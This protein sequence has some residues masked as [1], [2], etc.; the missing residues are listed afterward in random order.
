MSNIISCRTGVFGDIGEAFQR[1][2]RAGVR[3]AETPPAPEGDYAG[4]AA[5]A[6]A[7]GVAIATISTQLNVG[8]DEQAAALEPVI[9]GAASIGVAK[10]FISIK[11]GEDTPPADSYAR[12]RRISEYAAARGVSLCMETH[13][14]FGTNGDVARQTIEAVN[15]PAFRYN[16]DTA[17]IYYYNEGT[18]SVTELKK[19]A[20][21]VGSVHLKDTDG[22]Y[23]SGYFPELGQGVVD[24]PEVFR[25]L[26]A[27]GFL[28]PYT[29]ELEGNCLGPLAPEERQAFLERCVAYLRSIG[30]MD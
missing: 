12:M 26:G 5:K 23:H 28:G 22:G 17:N 16:F 7:A 4:M 29:M 24:F 3:F 8:T 13:P 6:R 14:P 1:F 2:A 25:I 10:I 19:A 30:A 18:D 9:D 15:H 27:Q 20:P 21:Y 11:P